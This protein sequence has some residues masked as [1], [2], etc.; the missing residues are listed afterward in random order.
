MTQSA[1][2][3]ARAGQRAGQRAGRG[4]AGRALAAA[5]W[6]LSYGSGTR[7]P[8]APKAGRRFMIPDRNVR[9]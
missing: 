8:A 1:E 9:I 5:L 3:R 2:G 6:Y 7:D 4:G